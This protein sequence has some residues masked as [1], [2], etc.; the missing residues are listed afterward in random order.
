MPWQFVLCWM[1]D[2]TYVTTWVRLGTHG[3]S[4]DVRCDTVAHLGAGRTGDNDNVQHTI[5]VQGEDGAYLGTLFNEDLTLLPEPL[6]PFPP[7]RSPTRRCSAA[8]NRQLLAKYYERFLSTSNGS[9]A[10]CLA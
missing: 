4:V 2:A 3:A 9:A 7:P 8:S 1:L 5:K 10:C 6:P